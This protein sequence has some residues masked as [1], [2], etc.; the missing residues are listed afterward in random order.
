MWN[1]SETLI[2]IGGKSPFE[3]SEI[4][5]VIKNQNKASELRRGRG[6]V[7]NFGKIP[8]FDRFFVLTASLI[9]KRFFCRL[10]SPL[11]VFRAIHVSFTVIGWQR[12]RLTAVVDSWVCRNQ[13]KYNESCAGPMM[14]QY[15][16]Y[17]IIVCSVFFFT[18]H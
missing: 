5:I 10:P 16:Q 1:P 17:Q 15:I 3:V 11:F 2:V 4:L 13:W 8:K 12:K 7:S 18:R 6:G 9:S 14:V